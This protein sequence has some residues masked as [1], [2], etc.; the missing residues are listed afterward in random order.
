MLLHTWVWTV[1]DVVEK[2]EIDIDVEDWGLGKGGVM[3]NGM[4]MDGMVRGFEKLR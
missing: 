1:C 2:I 3:D 4:G